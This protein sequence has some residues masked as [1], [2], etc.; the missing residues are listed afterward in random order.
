MKRIYLSLIF[1]FVFSAFQG[2]SQD[3]GTVI[4]KEQEKALESLINSQQFRSIGNIDVTIPIKFHSITRSDGTGGLSAQGRLNLLDKINNYY[5]N[6]GITFQDDGEINFIPSDELFDFITADA[7]KATVGNAQRGV[8]NVFLF[9]SI[10]NNGR[11]LCGYTFFPP[12]AD[13]IFATYG[14]VS[15]ANTT[16]EHELG[17]YFTLFH[18]HG[19][20]NTGTTDELVNG[21]N[22]GSAGD[23]LCDTPADPNL[24]GQVNQ[25]CAYVG[26]FRDANGD[27]YQ[28]DVS[29]IMAYSLDQC[30]N[31]F[32]PDQYAR[33]RQGFENGRSYLNFTSSSFIATFIASSRNVC[34]DEEV[35][36]EANSFGATEYEWTFQG[37]TPQK[38]TSLNPKVKYLNG[39]KFNVEL[40][41]FNNAGDSVV[42]SRKQLINVVDPL[43]GALNEPINYNLKTENLA[44]NNLKIVNPDLAFT[45]EKDTLLIEG[46]SIFALKMN[47]FDYLSEALP[48][49]D[50]V[51]SPYYNNSGV[52]QYNIQIDYAYTYIP[53][54]VGDEITLPIY[55]SLSVLLDTECSGEPTV[56][57]SNGGEGLATV[58]PMSE[59]FTPTL[60]E[61][62]KKI[63]LNFSPTDQE[64]LRLIIRSNSYNGNNL[65]IKGIVVTPD[66][67]VNAPSNFRFVSVS[68]DSLIFRWL[69]QSNNELNFILEESSDGITFDKEYVANK[70][71]QS[72]KI[73]VNSKEDTYYRL[74]AQ[75]R[76]GFSSEYTSTELVSSAILSNKN[77]FIQEYVLYPNPV[78]NYLYIQG[79]LKKSVSFKIYNSLGIQLKSGTINKELMI[80]FSKFSTGL[81]F[82]KLGDKNTPVYKIIKK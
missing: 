6:A 48:N 50:E 74:K 14:C 51:V 79:D 29:N 75:G 71:A 28:P 44:G 76:E 16:L 60:Y 52:S 59:A 8:I 23:R 5:S 70:N 58:E 39:G 81:Y 82:V 68:S 26:N 22:C 62:F 19:T 66:F 49:V 36:F 24:S 67:S 57:Y 3:C 20:T 69:D 43:N 61:N 78:D 56:A 2:I 42:V 25:E 17:H 37:G 35:I 10:S 38:S 32:S 45:F 4:S 27:L 47:N 21:S 65:Y 53:S 40:K 46:D 34:V 15:G 73:P 13:H 30:Q 33:I 63:N 7:G 64:F 18:T 54:T 41:V 72:I 11:A 1:I 9:N 77:G 31:K 12:S 55:D 80:D